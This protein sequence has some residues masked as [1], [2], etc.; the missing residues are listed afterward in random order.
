MSEAMRPTTGVSLPELNLESAITRLSF[1]LKP[2]CFNDSHFA[3]GSQLPGNTVSLGT[4][5]LQ[6]R[7]L[8]NVRRKRDKGIN[9]ET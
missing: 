8:L 5:R 6:R 4:M 1:L 2:M 9:H 3:F 7:D